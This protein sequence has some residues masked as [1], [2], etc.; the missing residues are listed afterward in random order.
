MLWVHFCITNLK[1]WKLKLNMFHGYHLTCAVFFSHGKT[2]HPSAYGIDLTTK[3]FNFLFSSDV[4]KCCH[5]RLSFK[6]CIK[7][8][9]FHWKV[10]SYS[11]VPDLWS[12][13]CQTSLTLRRSSPK[14]SS[15]SVPAM[16]NTL[17]MQQTLVSPD[18]PNLSL[19]DFQEACVY[20]AGC[21]YLYR[22]SWTRTD[23][24]IDRYSVAYWVESLYSAKLCPTLSKL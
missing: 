1:H 2:A 20:P 8:S 22:F 15:S 11:L 7:L 24:Y 5:Y 17:D 18:S 12:S 21:F 14:S 16:G 23:F 6:A 10:F 19:L 13:P 9:S 4:T 3:P